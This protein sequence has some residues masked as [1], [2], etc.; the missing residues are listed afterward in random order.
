MG[1]KLSDIVSLFKNGPNHFSIIQPHALGKYII[2]FACMLH[3]IW[4]LLLCFDTQVGNVTPIAILFIFLEQSRFWV[5]ITLWAVALMAAGF[6][7]LRIRKTANLKIL[8]L[9][10][11]PQQLVLWLSASAGIYAAYL[12]HYADGTACDWGH[13][14]ADQLPISLLAI[15]YTITLIHTRKIPFYP[16][17]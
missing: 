13:I 7:N 2:L 11:V 6:V 3:I 8:S 17:T 9:L 1:I 16:N 15:L 14:F 12:Q 4:G 5:I 10:L